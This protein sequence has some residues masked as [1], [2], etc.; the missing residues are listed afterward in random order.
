[1][2]IDVGFEYHVLSHFDANGIAITIQTIILQNEEWE[3]EYM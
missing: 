3:I 2:F 1:M